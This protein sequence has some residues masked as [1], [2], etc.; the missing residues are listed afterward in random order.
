VRQ[1][2]T[3]PLTRPPDFDRFW[4]ATL[5][6]LDAV[7]PDVTSTPLLVDPLGIELNLLTFRSFA[8]APISMYLASWRDGR[9]RPVVVH[10][11]GYRDDGPEIQ[12]EWAR[13]GLNVAGVDIRGYGRSRQTCQRQ[14]P[15]GW[16][17]TGLS[18]PE[19]SILRGAV[20]DFVRGVTLAR[21]RLDGH[22]VRIVVHGQ[23]FAG[24]LAVM[25]EGIRPQGDLLAL[26]VP[27]LGWAEGRLFFVKG[28]SGLEIVRYLDRFPECAEDVMGTLRYFDPINFAGRVACPTLVG[29]G[30]VD[31]IT[32]PETVY[33]I[34]N[35]LQVPH[36]VLEFA[37]SHSK[38]PEEKLWVRFDQRWMELGLQG[39]PRDFG[40]PAHAPVHRQAHA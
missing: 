7:D 34:A 26:A 6:A 19:T 11:H 12:M 30:L 3:P 8:G 32:P 9:P 28:G 13:A 31:S 18:S 24:G 29:V 40:H 35:H 23:S 15:W 38:L 16:A 20:C 33:P 21:E 14:S 39:V 10:S 27:T 5:Q 37:V 17:L 36:E 25:A 22:A 4:H 2:F 1:T